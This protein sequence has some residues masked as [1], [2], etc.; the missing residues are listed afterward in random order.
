M[1]RYLLF[2]ATCLFYANTHAQES[3]HTSDFISLQECNLCDYRQRYTATFSDGH[4]EQLY[5]SL[6]IPDEHAQYDDPLAH[7]KILEYFD[8]KGYALISTNG[9]KN[10]GVTEFIFKRK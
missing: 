1:K 6:K 5:D 9:G 3:E 4:T 2:I 8:K 7:I 10:S